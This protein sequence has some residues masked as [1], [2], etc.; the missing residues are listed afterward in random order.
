MSE[1]IS[2]ASNI[3]LINVKIVLHYI[4]LIYFVA[5][6]SKIREKYVE[7]ITYLIPSIKKCY[8]ESINNLTDAEFVQML[9]LDGC[10]ILQ[11]LIN[12]KLYDPMST[13]DVIDPV[14]RVGWNLPLIS[15]DLLMLEN[16]IPF[17]VLQ[18]LYE[19]Y[20]FAET[21]Q[22]SKPSLDDLLLNF[23]EWV[24]HRSKTPARQASKHQIDHL[25]HFY[26]IAYI[27]DLEPNNSPK[28][29]NFISKAVSYLSLTSR[30]Q[31]EI[32][33]SE[34]VHPSG[35][36][37]RRLKEPNSSKKTSYPRMIPCAT[38]LRE[39]GITFKKHE[40]PNNFLDISFVRGVLKIPCSS[41]E[42][43][44]K[45]KYMNLVAFEQSSGMKTKNMTSY[46][47]FMDFLLNTGKDVSVLQRDGIIENKLA[48]EDEVAEFFSQLHG[49]CY[50]NFDKHHLAPV[51]RDVESYC[52]A[53]W[54][55][56]RAKLYRDYFRNPWAIL[57]FCAALLV[58][59]I[60]VFRTVCFI[61]SAFFHYHLT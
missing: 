32:C 23:V 41:I 30:P 24:E 49:C 55:K 4:F 44:T 8:F 9:L 37:T 12:L 48:N 42:E 33:R 5:I 1:T 46:A 14:F 3:T 45:P 52:D 18:N 10:F 26:Y 53:F 40:Q 59:S 43:A 28:A 51:F 36:E 22:T 15:T 29:A 61:L 11:L 38:E 25:L 13:C 17:S 6:S 56:H 27:P 50:I 21:S 19:I 16:Q 34:D 31:E 2:N 58:L 20:S 54:P 60:T 57:S 7:R 39:F 35:S 47:L